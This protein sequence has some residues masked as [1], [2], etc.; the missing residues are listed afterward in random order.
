MRAHIQSMCSFFNKKAK[1]D[2]LAKTVGSSLGILLII[3][4]LK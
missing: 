3:L 4:A 1:T 2:V